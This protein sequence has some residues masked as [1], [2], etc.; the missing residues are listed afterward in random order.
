MSS[1]CRT[2]VSHHRNYHVKLYECYSSAT[3]GRPGFH[4]GTNMGDNQGDYM[5]IHNNIL[6]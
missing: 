5:L 2:I 1:K 3:K 6:K 4:D